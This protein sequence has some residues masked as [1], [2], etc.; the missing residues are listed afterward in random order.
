MRR[1]RRRRRRRAAGALRLRQRR[2]GI[3]PCGVI[4]F[5]LLLSTN[6]VAPP[7]RLKS[8]ACAASRRGVGAALAAAGGRLC[9]QTPVRRSGSPTP[10]QPV[11]LTETPALGRNASH[12]LLVP[13]RRHNGRKRARQRAARHV[14]KVKSFLLAIWERLVR[15]NAS[16]APAVCTP[17]AQ[18]F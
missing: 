1:R 4:L 2:R 3:A 5:L 16:I 11:P 14:A 18:G 13:G 7:A 15:E 6:L 8:A 9:R 12:R 17:D 10:C